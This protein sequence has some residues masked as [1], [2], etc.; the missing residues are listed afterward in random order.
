MVCEPLQAELDRMQ[1]EYC[2]VVFCHRHDPETGMEVQCKCCAA[3]G[4]LAGLLHAVG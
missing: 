4:S 3:A 1:L 2:D